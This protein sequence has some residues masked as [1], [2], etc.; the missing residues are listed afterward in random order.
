MIVTFDEKTS[1]TC[2]DG[3]DGKIYLVCEFEIGITAPPFHPYCRTI[4]VPVYDMDNYKESKTPIEKFIN[5]S[6]DETNDRGKNKAYV[7]K[8]V[9]GFTK[10]NAEL[11]V[12]QI[13][14]NVNRGLVSPYKVT[15]TKYGKV[16]RLK[17]PVNGANNIKRKVICVYQIDNGETNPRMIT[18]YVEK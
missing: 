9:L 18:N 14:N 10:N 8:K 17:V 13:I 12:K 7:Y 2:S 1:K 4:T 6:L 3:I 11:L 15:T 16:F 5:Y